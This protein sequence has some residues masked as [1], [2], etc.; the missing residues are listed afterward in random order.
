MARRRLFNLLPQ[1]R[2]HDQTA[3]EVAEVSGQRFC[4]RPDQEHG[5]T[6]THV[7]HA[8]VIPCRE[9][10]VQLIAE[11]MTNLSRNVPTCDCIPTLSE[12]VSCTLERKVNDSDN[13]RGCA[14]MGNISILAA[15]LSDL[16]PS[17][18]RKSAAAH[19][20]R[21]VADTACTKHCYSPGAGT[22]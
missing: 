13:K 18:R 17:C 20:S 3:A 4:I 1:S 2:L 22:R 19:Q 11:E 5:V 15:S 10:G 21:S 14:Y 12:L 8:G 9:G 7:L 6:S 16:V